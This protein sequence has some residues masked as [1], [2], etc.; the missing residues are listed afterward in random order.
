MSTALTPE[1]QN[2]RWYQG[3]SKYCWVVL[4]I[5]ALGWMFD[6]M[7]Q[8]LFNLVR[9]PSTIDLLRPH[10]AGNPAGLDAK[11]KEVGGILTSVFL[12][13]WSIGGFL[14]GVIGDRLGRAKTMI[15][16]ILVYAVFTGLS[17]VATNWY[18]YAAFR[19]LTAL[20]VGG[21]FAA[22]AALVA[23]TFPSR[24]RP[25][26]LGTLQALSAVG[27]MMA[28]VVTLVISA[29]FGGLET[30][31]RWAYFVGAAPALLVFWIAK[32]VHEPEAWKQ[33]KQKASIDQE[34]GG[35]GQLFRDDT[36]R[37]RTIAGVLL[38]TAGVGGLWGVGFFSPDMLNAELIS[39]GIRKE[40]IGNYTSTMYF[41]QQLGAFLGAYTFSVFTEK[42]SRR[43]AF[44]LGYA[45]SWVSVLAFFWGIQGAGSHAF[46]RAM[47]LAPIMG[48]C[49][50]GPFAGFT[51]YFP[52]LFPTR[53]RATGCGFCY[54]AARVLAAAAPFALG[55][56]AAKLGGFAQAATVVT[57]IYSLGFIGAFLGPETRGQPL[58]EENL[59][60]AVI[61][62]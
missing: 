10:Y 17:G 42:T 25:M 33:A 46:G 49:T 7:D 12:I 8:N 50:L 43:L 37:R 62:D 61:A 57:C 6:T 24:S 48:F 31:W 36:L 41:V 5:A 29:G 35:I 11:A 34:L 59:A 38:A 45:L 39:A 15:V 44:T 51:I 21:E 52:E 60:Q 13:G 55:A 18:V 23:E 26:A 27:N 54:N 3:L 4:L 47:I 40:K 30:H 56:L 2:L 9:R 58:P 1:S 14:F 28:A 16:T 53:L 19:F 20:G 32:D 22:G